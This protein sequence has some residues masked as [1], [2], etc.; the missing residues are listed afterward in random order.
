VGL[1]AAWIFVSTAFVMSDIITVADNLGLLSGMTE[2]LSSGAS[3]DIY[4]STTVGQAGLLSGNGLNWAEA[5]E[6]VARVSLPQ[7]IL[8]VSIALLYLS[9]IAIWWARRTRQEIGQLI[10]G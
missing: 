5:V 9:W 4:L 3:N 6:T 7:V 2:W 1:L 10:E 8:Q